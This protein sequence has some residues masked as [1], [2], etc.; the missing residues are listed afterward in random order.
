MYYGWWLTSGNLGD[1]NS[2]SVKQGS[3]LCIP[4]IEL[5]ILWAKQ[6]ITELNPTLNEKA[7][8]VIRASQLSL[9]WSYEKAPIDDQK[10]LTKQD[11]QDHSY[12]S[13]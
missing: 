12:N 10:P 1:H 7:R 3:K 4:G 13:Y 8:T 6:G 9:A 5:L 2:R 11:H